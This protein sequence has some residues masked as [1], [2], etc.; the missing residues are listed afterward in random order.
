MVIFD[1]EGVIKGRRGIRMGM[2]EDD[3]DYS[4][5]PT[6]GHKIWPNL[7]ISSWVSSIGGGYYSYF[8]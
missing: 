2:E 7:G 3:L 6:K 4:S 1:C 8:K 5:D